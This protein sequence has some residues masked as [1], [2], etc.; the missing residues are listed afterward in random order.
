[1]GLRRGCDERG[2]VDRI[3]WVVLGTAGW[4][5][6][7]SRALSLSIDYDTLPSAIISALW[8]V[9]TKRY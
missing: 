8:L 2:C 1:V 6:G 7:L 9:A 4:A 3:C 5:A